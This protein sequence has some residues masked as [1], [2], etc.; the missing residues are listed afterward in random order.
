MIKMIL[1]DDEPLVLIG[2]QSMLKWEDY[3]VE[4]CGLA[5]NGSELLA[6]IEKHSPQLVIADIKMPVTSG[7]EALKISRERF[8]RLPLFIMLTS[9]QDFGL[10][11]DVIS[12]QAVDYLVKLELTPEVLAASVRKA[13]DL[14]R[15]LKHNEIVQRTPEERG[16]MQPFYDKFFMKLLS[17]LFEGREQFLSQKKELDL[18]FSFP[19]YCVCYCEVQRG[20]DMEISVERLTKLYFSTIQMVRETVTKFM[21]CYI[22]GLDTRHF[23]ITFCL[24]EQEEPV[25]R[26]VLTD[27]L[28]KVMTIIHNYFNTG[29]VCA[30]GTRVDDPYRLS[31]SFFAARHAFQSTSSDNRIVFAEEAGPAADQTDVFDMSQYK[32]DIAKAFEELDTS[33]LSELIHR[34]VTY[35]SQNPSRYLQAMDAACSLL[36]MAIS[37]F[38]DGETI[39]SEAFQD[40]PEGYRSIYQKHTTGEII[41]WMIQ[42]R[43]GLCR[44]LEARRQNYKNH[45]V[46]SVQKYIRQN[47][48]K[49]LTLNEVAARFGFSP[50]YLSQLF[51]HYA[52]YSFVE[53]I[54]HEKIAAAKTMML[55]E[56]CKIYEIAGHLGFDSAF[57]FSKVFKK[58]EG[59]SPRD[60]M[61][62]IAH[63]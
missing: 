33:V 54:A 26:S 25:Y 46:D 36:Y 35:F 52:E 2:M 32:N 15:D 38:P 18:D 58:I 11:K 9:Y 61:K 53:Y 29:L 24:S 5:H 31:E 48:D 37:F 7:L 19:S 47:L 56:N 17:N 55:D 57:Y 16:G 43:D 23:C 14:L 41:A 40:V 45:I 8:G 12:N 59:C 4:I 20:N 3:D 50:N 60:Y 6:M 34:I 21:A 10:V 51:T 27:V 44:T 30:V 62:R 42:L 63:Q 1:A 13:I 22:T 28:K 39:I 49:R